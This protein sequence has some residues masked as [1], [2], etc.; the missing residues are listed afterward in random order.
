MAGSL[1]SLAHLP[2]PFGSD[3]VAHCVFP[4]TGVCI[5]PDS[6]WSPEYY[7]LQSK[8]EAQAIKEREAWVLCQGYLGPSDR[9]VASVSWSPSLEGSSSEKAGGEIGSWGPVGPSG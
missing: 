5:S 2:P 3:L 9:I 7:L 8:M 4:V 6:T 1:L